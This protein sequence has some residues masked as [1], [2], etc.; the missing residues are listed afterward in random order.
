MVLV[1]Y[2]HIPGDCQYNTWLSTDIIRYV[3]Q[4]LRDRDK[5]SPFC[6]NLEAAIIKL[7]YVSMTRD[8][9]VSPLLLTVRD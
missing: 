9:N 8:R 4:G 5:S 1:T 3:E 2:G 7:C 6:L